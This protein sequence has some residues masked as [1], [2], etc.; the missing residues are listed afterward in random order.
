MHLPRTFDL[1]GDARAAVAQ[2]MG[3]M[4]DQVLDGADAPRWD[5][6]ELMR[7]EHR[8]GVT[9][10]VDD[11]GIGPSEGATVTVGME[12]V[13]LLLDAMAYTEVMSEG[14]AWI[15]MVRWTADFI[16]SEL[17]GHWTDEE[18]REFTAAGTRRQGRTIY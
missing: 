9:M 16:T 17:R 15:D 13:A 3:I 7:L 18:W 5:Y 10:G 12:D 8:F 11:I 6:D 2:L 14:F 4:N 1:S